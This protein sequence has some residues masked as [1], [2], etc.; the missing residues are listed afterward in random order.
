[1]NSHID[2]TLIEQLNITDY[3]I[4]Q[5]KNLLD[6]TKEDEKRL[7]SC[8]DFIHK[9][10]EDVIVKFYKKLTSFEE[11]D[12]IIGDSDT[13]NRLKEAQRKYILELFDGFY[14]IDYV[15]HRLRIGMV[16]KRIG[17]EPKF[18]LSAVKMLRDILTEN[19][20]KN[21][22]GKENINPTIDSLDKILLFD[23]QFIID[24]Y[25]RSHLA[26]AESAR[27]KVKF[28]ATSLEEKVAERTRE[29]KELSM[30]DPLTGLFNRRAFHKHIRKNIAFA[31]RKKIPVSF[32]YFDVDDFKKINDTM[33]HL[34]GDEVL[35]T[36]GNILLDITREDDIPCRYGGDEFCI[37]ILGETCEEAENLSRRLIE[38]FSKKHP[39]LTISIGISQTGPETFSD[40]ETLLLEADK[41]MYKAKEQQGSHIESCRKNKK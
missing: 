23:T 17:V 2:K 33:G 22:Q 28:Y 13:L 8:K 3:E 25:I 7:L 10:L 16:H 36:I 12:L 20:S 31:E 37:F 5:R 35:K 29:L 21:L 27:E 41:L 40:T 30:K 38:A 32:I 9:N 1:M 34:K 26:E 18:Y 6:F 4:S 14:D 24:T 19:I 11:I 15:N 39:G